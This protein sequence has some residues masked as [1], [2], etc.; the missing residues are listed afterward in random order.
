MAG[1]Q[2]ENQ[3][4]KHWLLGCKEQL[5][6]W[7]LIWLKDN[8]HILIVRTSRSRSQPKLNQYYKNSLK[9]QMYYI[10]QNKLLFKLQKIRF[11][12]KKLTL[13]CFAKYLVTMGILELIQMDPS[14]AIRTKNYKQN[15]INATINLSNPR[16]ILEPARWTVL[17][18]N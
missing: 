2:W 8:H 9:F 17:L 6:M 5:S 11:L 4:K 16:R 13:K 1:S 3:N 18:I 10:D 7:I 12:Q 15:R 14:A